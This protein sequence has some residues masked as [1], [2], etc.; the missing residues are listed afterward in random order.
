MNLSNLQEMVN[1]REAWRAAVHGIIKSLTGLSDWIT[2][3]NVSVQFSHSV[4]SNS[5]Q[6]H[7]LQ[8][9]RPPCHSPTPEACSNSCSWSQWC[10]PIISSSVIPISSRLRSVPA[11]GSFQMSQFFFRWSKYWSLSFSI[12][13]SKEYSGLIS[14]KIY[15]LDLLAVQGTQES[16]PTSQFK[17]INSLALSLLYGPTLTSI[18]DYWKNH[19]FN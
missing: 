8:H 13:P 7:G 12:S 18:H 17:N 9:A 14:F 6:P 11:T 5:W 10:H 15:W 19:S 4:G 16:S 2:T 3:T 1:D